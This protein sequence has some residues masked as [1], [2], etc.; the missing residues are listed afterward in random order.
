M[1]RRF[2]LFLLFFVAA[3]SLLYPQT[4]DSARDQRI[5]TQQA[6]HSEEWVRHG[7]IYE[8]YTRSFSPEGT[9][10]GI[11]KRL[12][13]LKKLGVTILWLMPIHPV[14]VLHR[15]G[16][17]GSPYSVQDYYAVNPEFG[18]I[19]D[20]KRLVSR[21]HEHGFH[22]IID[23]VANHTAWDS[24]L[25]NEHPEWFTKD[26]AGNI[27]SPN[28]DWTDVAD[29]DYSQPGL[30]R[31]MIEMMKYWVRDVDIDGFRCDVAEMV[32]TDFWENARSALDSIK[33]VM[34]LS[35]G[36]YP[37]HHLRAFDA[38]YSWKIYHALS[39]IIKGETPASVFDSEL[40]F[41][42]TSYPRNALRM[43]FSSNH[44]ENAWDASDVEKF[45]GDGA[46]LAAVLVNTIPGIPL[47]YNGQEVG[48]KRKLGLFEK[49]SIDWK[50]GD[51]FRTLYARLFELRRDQPAFFAGEMLHIITTND[52]RVFAFAR[53]SGPNKFIVVCNFDT[54][55]FNGTIDLSS[56]KLEINNQITLTDVFS[57]HT[58]TTRLLPSKSTLLEVPAVGFR[59]VQIEQEPPH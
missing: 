44:D 28:P 14:G 54:S 40:N 57:S 49:I 5:S 4:F 1:G 12:P 6:R 38:T 17:L 11:E 25:I 2:L 41:E 52:K 15:K 23:L 18:T 3:S 48:N 47:L 32:P 37:E 51:E 34:M 13:E 58:A 33:P 10:A 7:V 53:V 46:K 22:I 29:L 24:K 27:I 45:G 26:R 16:T 9:F 35:E 30:R 39:S 42:E 43:R 55:P 19:D 20:F 59:I 56:P 36:S 8:I 31:S 50:G 21:A